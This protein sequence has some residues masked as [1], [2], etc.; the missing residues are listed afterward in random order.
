MQSVLLMILD[1]WGH[2]HAAPDNA[3]SHANTP[4][5]DMLLATCPKTLI[6]TA[7]KAVGLPNE[8]MGNS[9]VGHMNIGAGRVVYQSLTRI[10]DAL[11]E[12]RF[13]QTEALANAC[14]VPDN[15][16]LH[17]LG[18]LS[19]GGVHSHEDHIEALIELAKSK[20]VARIYLHVFTDGRDT[21]P[22]SAEASLKRFQALEDQQFK[23]A[24]I[25]GRYFAMD[26]DNNWERTQTAYEAIADNQAEFRAPRALDA[27][28]QAYRR[29]ENDEFIQATVLDAA[30][31]MQ[32]G[33]HLVFMNFRADRARQL[34]QLFAENT[35]HFPHRHIQLNQLVTLTQYQQQLQT[36]VAFP[37]IAIHNGLGEVL[38]H[39]GAKQLRIAET[40]KYAHVTYF[41]N[42]GE[43]TV[44]PGEDRIL[45]QSPAVATYDLKPE[46][47]VSEVTE[48]LTAAIQTNTY[49][50]ICLNFANPDMVGHTGVFSAAVKAVEAVDEAMGKVINAARA[51]QM[52]ILVTA[53]HGNVEQMTN[54]ETGKPFTSHTTF[55]VP[56]LLVNGDGKRLTD[57]GALCDLA[58]TVLALMDIEQPPEMTGKS[59]IVA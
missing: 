12:H 42:G 35:T 50:F 30:E 26:R 13:Q 44:F 22:R 36:T 2:A 20:G 32:D 9:E 28:A 38:A 58:P 11:H 1:G 15:Q 27:L 4:N 53:D 41:F 16:A 49:D 5:W 25:T 18:L 24:T 56:L 23:I 47:A 52:K 34:T 31:R 46:M 3:I 8:Q 40:E 17:I 19:A 10:Q 21:P 14:D 39:A 51:N 43:E 57:G 6:K 54:P 7:G 59:L 29:D 37:P 33:D 55:P 48:K 45:V